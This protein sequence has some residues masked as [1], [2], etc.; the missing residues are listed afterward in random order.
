MIAGIIGFVLSNIDLISSVGGGASLLLSGFLGGWKKW[1]A[2][3][4]VV[5]TLGGWIAIE[6]IRN[7]DLH[8]DLAMARAEASVCVAGALERDRTIANLKEANTNLAAAYDELRADAEAAVAA[9]TNDRDR[10]VEE[11][12]KFQTLREKIHATAPACVGEPPAY[13]AVLDWLRDTRPQGP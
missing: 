2:I 7:A 5:A 1:I 9:V 8:A 10:Q 12:E 11:L 4:A 6:K 3:A 13:G